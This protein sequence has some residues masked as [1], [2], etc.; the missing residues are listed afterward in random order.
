MVALAYTDTAYTDIPAPS[1][2]P[3]RQTVTK[4]D[5]QP[6]GAGSDPVVDMAARVLSVP[7]RHL[8]AVLWRSGLLWVGR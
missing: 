7:L 2:R 3:V 4:L 6:V 8:Y 5:R 1:T